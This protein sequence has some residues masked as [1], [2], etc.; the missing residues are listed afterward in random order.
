MFATA[1]DYDGQDAHAITRQFNSSTSTPHDNRAHVALYSS[2]LYLLIW[3]GSQ[4]H[5]DDWS[6]HEKN[7]RRTLLLVIHSMSGRSQ[8]LPNSN[9]LA[10]C[11]DITTI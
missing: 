6:V 7:H 1:R 3:L 8:D 9:S 10:I 11:I 2:P 5:M 4:V